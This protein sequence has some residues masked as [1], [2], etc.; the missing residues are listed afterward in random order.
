MTR[1]L[2]AQHT[3]GSR[4][5][6]ADAEEGWQKGE[7]VK[8]DGGRLHVRLDEGGQER[9]C[10]PED[11]P[12]QNP[13]LYGNGVEVGAAQRRH[14]GGGAVRWAAMRSSQEGPPRICAWCSAVPPSSQRTGWNPGRSCAG[15]P[16]SGV[17]RSPPLCLIPSPLC[18]PQDMTTLNYLNEP[19]VLWNLKVRHQPRLAWSGSLAS[20]C[21]HQGNLVGRHCGPCSAAARSYMPYGSDHSP[22]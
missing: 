22:R 1:P 17:A 18:C 2:S 7:V 11:C 19:G 12:L 5:W 15:L 10:D 14:M 9:V 21:H 16:L 6:L 20:A 8:I 13:S 3:V 4:V